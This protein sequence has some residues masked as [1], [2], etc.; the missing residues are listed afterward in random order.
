MPPERGA[1][2]GTA[3]AL[4]GALQLVIGAVIMALGGWVEDGTAQ[5]M[6]A[7][8]AVSAILAC[9]VSFAVLRRPQLQPST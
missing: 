9:V 4:Q 1:V 8:I 2:A 6:I 3:S 7:T 5:P